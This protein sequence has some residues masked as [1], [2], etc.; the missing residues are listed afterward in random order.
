VK[1]SL[2]F[3]CG[4]VIALAAAF[5][6]VKYLTTPLRQQLQ[7]LCGNPATLPEFVARDLYDR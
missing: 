4:L 1:V 5:T 6:V 7:E 3:A 2:T